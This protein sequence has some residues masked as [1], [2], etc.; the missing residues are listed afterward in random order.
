MKKLTFLAILLCLTAALSGCSKDAAIESFIAEF[1]SVTMKMTEKIEAGDV[2]GARKAFDE[3]K[4][5]LESSWS[6]IKGARGFQVSEEMQKKLT[7]SVSK[8]MA[9]LTG[10]V[11]KGTMKMGGDQA[12]ADALKALLEEYKNV[13]TM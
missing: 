8:N 5:S 10:S 2:D 11:F 12:K 6:D 4:A 9:A 13:F 1:D 3:S 7:E